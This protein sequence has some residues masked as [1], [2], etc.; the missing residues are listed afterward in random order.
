M[1]EASRLRD[2]PPGPVLMAGL[3]DIDPGFRGAPRCGSSPPSTA[4]PT[5]WLIDL[6]NMASSDARFVRGAFREALVVKNAHCILPYCGHDS[7]RCEGE[8]NVAWPRGHTTMSNLAPV[9]GKHHRAKTHAGWRLVQALNGIYLWTSP[10]GRIYLADHR[11]ITH[12]VGLPPA[13]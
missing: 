10:N 11:G 8:H 5:G 3:A 9:H 4:S 2:V 12:D 13:R 7:R 1:F 6:D